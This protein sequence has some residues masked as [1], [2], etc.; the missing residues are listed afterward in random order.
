MMM[1]TTRRRRR[2]RQNM[3]RKWRQTFYAVFL[4]SAQIK[5]FFIHAKI[6]PH[7]HNIYIPQPSSAS[8]IENDDFRVRDKIK[9]INNK[10]GEMLRAFE[11]FE[12]WDAKI[13]AFVGCHFHLQCCCQYHH[14]HPTYSMCMGVLLSRSHSFARSFSQSSYACCCWWWRWI[15]ILIALHL[16]SGYYAMPSINRNK[17][18]YMKIDWFIN[19]ISRQFFIFVCHFNQLTLLQ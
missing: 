11:L 16:S 2:R 7:M 8:S 14:S 15:L 13:F 5:M 3:R 10:M 12:F 19:L 17:M 1:T 4:N 6:F 18:P 9:W